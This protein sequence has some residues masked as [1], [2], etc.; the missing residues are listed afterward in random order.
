V[1]GSLGY[2]L[3]VR[4]RQ[5]TGVRGDLTIWLFPTAVKWLGVVVHWYALWRCLFYAG[6]R[7]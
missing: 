4:K 7:E 3:K 2:A 6:S 5:D 1:R